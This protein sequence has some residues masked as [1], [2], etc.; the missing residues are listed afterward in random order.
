[1]DRT[2]IQTATQTMTTR[3]VTTT[4]PLLQRQQ[5]LRA[6]LLRTPAFLIAAARA[7][8]FD[9]LELPAWFRITSVRH[10]RDGY[11]LDLNNHLSVYFAPAD[12]DWDE[13]AE[14][15]L[16]EIRRTKYD[17]TLPSWPLEAMRV[18]T[19][20]KCPSDARLLSPARNN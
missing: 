15:A 20:T 4:A 13:T 18:T 5:V 1:M 6:A 16:V 7:E 10:A 12:D 2:G 14:K 17:D 11:A 3:T 9:G 19:T 8:D